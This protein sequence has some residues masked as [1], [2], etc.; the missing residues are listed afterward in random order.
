MTQ[1]LELCSIIAEQSHF[2]HDLD[3]KVEHLAFCMYVCWLL[4]ALSSPHFKNNITIE[5]RRG[6]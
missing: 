2:S 1:L 4:K 3:F 6:M 5:R